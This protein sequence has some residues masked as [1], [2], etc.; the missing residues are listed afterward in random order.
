M[1]RISGFYVTKNFSDNAKHILS[2]QSFYDITLTFS[3][4]DQ[5][6]VVIEEK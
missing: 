4:E 3:R 6:Q 1:S 5:N 2:L